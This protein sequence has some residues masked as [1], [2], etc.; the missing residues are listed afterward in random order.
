MTD[1]ESTTYH[2][3]DGTGGHQLSADSDASSYTL[4]TPLEVGLSSRSRQKAPLKKLVVV[5][6]CSLAVLLAPLTGASAQQPAATEADPTL[7][8]QAADGARMETQVATSGVRSAPPKLEFVQATGGIKESPVSWS[9]YGLD[10]TVTGFQIQARRNGGAYRTVKT[11]TRAD[12]RR[13]VVRSLRKG[14]YRFRVR[15]LN[16]STAGPTKV[17]WEPVRVCSRRL[18]A[19]HCSENDEGKVRDGR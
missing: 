17:A 1:T 7:P 2:R 15:A 3:G 11:V 9:W 4:A 16:G 19:R 5:A 18:P 6:S 8:V 14:N 12:A 13:T 10:P